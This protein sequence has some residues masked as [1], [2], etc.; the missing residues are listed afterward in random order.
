MIRP[1][2]IVLTKKTTFKFNFNLRGYT[3]SIYNYM[4]IHKCIQHVQLGRGSKLQFARKITTMLVFAQ[5][6]PNV[7]KVLPP[8]PYA[9]VCNSINRIMTF[10]G[11]CTNASKANVAANDRVRYD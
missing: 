4:Y 5:N 6:Y 1:H 7:S 9:Y 10:C 2:F 11:G 8:A 3:F